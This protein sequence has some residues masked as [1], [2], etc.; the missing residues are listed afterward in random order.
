MGAASHENWLKHPEAVS[1]SL[2]MELRESRTSYRRG[3]SLIELMVAV[4]IIGILGTVAIPK[5]MVYQ[6]KTKSAE[7][8]T[9]L[10]GV[11]TAQ[12]SYYSEFGSFIE[13][14][15]EPGVI[16][17]K[18]ATDFDS[19]TSDF[20]SLG[21]QPEGRVYFSY[22]VGINGDGTAYTADAGADIDGNGVIQYWGYAKP[23]SDGTIANSQVGCDIASITANDIVPCDPAAGQSIF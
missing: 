10:G 5:Y 4:A 19:I 22:G 16:P 17:G 11:R 13:A 9:N 1:D 6:L 15:P 14:S 21:W 23:E 20:Q 7:A 18:T 2:Q 8:K 3:F 12:E